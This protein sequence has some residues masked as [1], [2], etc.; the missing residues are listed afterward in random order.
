MERRLSATQER[1]QN[2]S[3]GARY[4]RGVGVELVAGCR[5][6]FKRRADVVRKAHCADELIGRKRPFAGP[7]GERARNRH[8]GADGRQTANTAT[9]VQAEGAAKRIQLGSELGR[10]VLRNDLGRRTGLLDELAEQL[11]NAITAPLTHQFAIDAEDATERG[12]L[13]GGVVRHGTH[14]CQNPLGVADV[15]GDG[16]QQHLAAVRLPPL[17]CRRYALRLGRTIEPQRIR[18]TARVVDHRAGQRGKENEVTFQIALYCAT[19][20]AGREAFSEDFA[21]GRRLLDQSAQGRIAARV[22]SHRPYVEH[23]DFK[24]EPRLGP[25]E[26]LNR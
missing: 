24:A 8:K 3:D 16:H 1:M 14:Q 21:Q 9:P 15:G 12:D 4:Q 26:Q 11:P 5:P 7:A 22:D 10:Y 23:F 18:A 17:D 13:L 2:L 20:R 6:D 25:F 19:G